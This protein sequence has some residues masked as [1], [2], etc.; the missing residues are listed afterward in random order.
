[1]FL[2]APFS[3]A[4]PAPPIGPRLLQIRRGYHWAADNDPTNVA[5]TARA[6]VAEEIS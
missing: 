4:L 1:M 5:E 2:S 6:F 3:A